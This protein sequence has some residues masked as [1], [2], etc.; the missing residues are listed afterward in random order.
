MAEKK[1]FVPD[2]EGV[3]GSMHGYDPENQG[4]TRQ[5]V[6]ALLSEFFDFDDLVMNGATDS[7]PAF[8]KYVNRSQMFWW[9]YYCHKDVQVRSR[10][11]GKQN[12]EA[13]SEWIFGDAEEI[14]AREGR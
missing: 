7:W 8:W 10:L 14:D 1:H 9:S 2:T 13:L 4:V 12:G 5:N 6:E 3:R 11:V